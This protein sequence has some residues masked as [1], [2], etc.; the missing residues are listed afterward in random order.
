MIK[1]KLHIWKHYHFLDFLLC[2]RFFVF[3]FF[4]LNVILQ[5]QLF[6]GV[7]NLFNQIGH[8]F[9]FL[10][11]L[12]VNWRLFYYFR[13]VYYLGALLSIL[14]NN[15][16]MNNFFLVNTQCIFLCLFFSNLDKN[17]HISIH[18]FMRFFF[19]IKLKLIK[20]FLLFN[21]KFLLHPIFVIIVK[22]I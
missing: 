13:I 11:I 20:V 14:N 7:L 10:N 9:L 12:L 2:S 17:I 18:N 1:S 16:R 22:N 4:I 19:P 3:H 5:K 6:I 15:L 21:S 8:L